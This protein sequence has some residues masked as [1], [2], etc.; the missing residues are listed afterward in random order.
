MKNIVII[1]LLSLLFLNP[2][3]S[4]HMGN[5]NVQYQVHLPA[6]VINVPYPNRDEF[7][8]TVKGLS[9]VAAD[10]YVAIFSLTQA[11]ETAAEVN[12]LIDNRIKPIEAYCKQSDSL[13]IFIDLITFMPIYELDLVKKV[14]NKK[15]YN[16]VPA[17]F[18]VKKNIHIKYKDP[19][20]LNKIIKMCSKSEIYDLVRVDYFSDQIEKQK[21][22]LMDKA[23]KRV[24]EQLG[25][26]AS[27]LGKEADDFTMQLSDGYTVVYPIEMYKQ[28]QHASTNKIMAQR[29][30]TVNKAAKTS[31]YY[32]KPYFDKG[33]DFTVNSTIFQPV[34][35][36]VYEIKVKYTPKPP[37]K[38]EVAKPTPQPV[39]KEIQVQKEVIIVTQNG[40]MKTVRL[41]Q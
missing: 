38:K 30:S 8:I 21:K 11:A 40:Q 4:Q 36:V 27:L 32:Y 1:S 29:G 9:N 31:S 12:E 26:R 24:K 3:H 18:E 13:D 17:G 7:V 16:E 2:L 15:T 6:Q 5:A 14:F 37:E 19:N 35:Q 20:Q 28:Y 23:V 41:N 34:I 25:A 39:K 22:L 33:F 10:N